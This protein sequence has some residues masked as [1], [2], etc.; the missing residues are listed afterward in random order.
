MFSLSN[1]C[2]LDK[3]CE[4]YRVEY[5]RQAKRFIDWSMFWKWNCKALWCYV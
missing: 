1:V 5:K 2:D 4:L 3:E